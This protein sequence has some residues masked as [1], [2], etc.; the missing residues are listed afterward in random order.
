MPPWV[1]GRAC[2]AQSA[3]VLGGAQVRL[4]GGDGHVT[5]SLVPPGMSSRWRRTRYRLLGTAWCVVATIAQVYPDMWPVAVYPDIRSLSV[6]PDMWPVAVYPDIRS[7]SVY[8]DLCLLLV[9]PD[10]FPLC[11]Y[12]PI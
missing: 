7:L 1:S 5:A 2:A 8:V 9:Y 10:M 11:R 3:R 6:Y 12:I 4:P